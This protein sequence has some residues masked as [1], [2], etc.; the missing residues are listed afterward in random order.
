MQIG[1]KI[2]VVLPANYYFAVANLPARTVSSQFIQSLACTLQNGVTELNIVCTVSESTLF[3]GNIQLII[4]AGRLKTGAATSQDFLF[5]ESTTNLRSVN[6]KMLPIKEGRILGARMQVASSDLFSRRISQSN[7]DFFF[8]T[9]GDMSAGSTITLLL[10]SSF[11]SSRTNPSAF[12]IAINGGPMPAVSCQLLNTDLLRIVCRI[13][14][15]NPPIIAMS[16]LYRLMFPPGQLTFGSHAPETS[17]GLVIQ[18]SEDLPSD[19]TR[20][21]RILVPQVMSV[22]MKISQQDSFT[23]RVTGEAVEFSFALQSDLQL[24]STITIMLPPNYFVNK[25]RPVASLMCAVC[26]PTEI[27]IVDCFLDS[28]ILT[29]VC[30]TSN[31]ILRAGLVTLFF[32]AGEMATGSFGGV[33]KTLGIRV[34]ASDHITSVML[35]APAIFCMPGHGL[36]K[37]GECRPCL[38]GEFSSNP[39]TQPCELCPTTA[40]SANPSSTVCSSCGPFRS[41]GYVGA[42]SQSECLCNDGLY[43]SKDFKCESCSPGGVCSNSQMLSDKQFWSDSTTQSAQPIPC[44]F[45]PDACLAGSKCIDGHFGF[46]CSECRTGYFSLGGQCKPCNNENRVQSTMIIVA[47]TFS[48]IAMIVL[49]VKGSSASI[50]AFVQMLQIETLAMY[51]D[52]S[53]PVA[54][55][56]ALTSLSVFSLNPELLMLECSMNV[57]DGP[58]DRQT[59]MI[60]NFQA[61]ITICSVGTYGFIGLGFLF[62]IIHLHYNRLKEKLAKDDKHLSHANK[63][64]DEFITLTMHKLYA[65]GLF[66]GLYVYLPVTVSSFEHMTCENDAGFSF[67]KMKPQISCYSAQWRNIVLPNCIFGFV[68]FTAGIPIMFCFMFMYTRKDRYNPV[69]LKS[70]AVFWNKYQP[71]LY[72]WEMVY[73]SRKLV[74]AFIIIFLRDYYLFQTTV[75]CVCWIAFMIVHFNS[76]PYEYMPLNRIESA[77]YL[78]AFFSVSIF[79]CPTLINMFTNHSTCDLFVQFLL[80][81]FLRVSKDLE[82]RTTYVT[83]NLTITTA[84]IVYGMMGFVQ[85]LKQTSK[86]NSILEIARHFNSLAIHLKDENVRLSFAVAALSLIRCILQR[87]ASFVSRDVEM[88]VTL[89]V[90]QSEMPEITNRWLLNGATDEEKRSLTL[91]LSCVSKSLLEQGELL[92]KRASFREITFLENSVPNFLRYLISESTVEERQIVQH[93]FRQMVQ[94]RFDRYFLDGHQTDLL[95]DWLLASDDFES[96]QHFVQIVFKLKHWFKRDELFRQIKKVPAFKKVSMEGIK[97][98]VSNVTLK[99][100]KGGEVIVVEGDEGDEM[101][102]ITEGSVVVLDKGVEYTDL[103]TCKV[104]AELGPGSYFGEMVLLTAGLHDKAKRTR[105]VVA[106]EDSELYVL[107]FDQFEVVMDMYPDLRWSINRE[108][109]LRKVAADAIAHSNQQTTKRISV[110]ELQDHAKRSAATTIEDP[111]VLENTRTTNFHG[112]EIRGQVSSTERSNPRASSG[113]HFN[114]PPMWCS[115]QTSNPDDSAGLE[116]NNKFSS[117]SLGTGHAGLLMETLKRKRSDQVVI[118]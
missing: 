71:S 86:S 5:V 69:F 52:T 76:N 8:A 72:W 16:G 32:R 55:Q 22:Q 35:E 47:F 17:G 85:E 74:M 10:P 87:D 41:T 89:L 56:T 20:T 38:P 34:A 68:F 59:S 65:C 117:T 19:G 4:D 95:S 93:L 24:G 105:T 75:F 25:S 26:A 82:Y 48:V 33:F 67:I 115:S 1:N 30:T 36:T 88:F 42:V 18:T 78:G 100:V 113:K 94:W 60:Y 50:N 83:L 110:I 6:G 57:G 14:E 80:T 96:V 66:F 102:F 99:F 107:K 61:F 2:I 23:N 27:P 15:A 97:A 108:A 31:F 98:L 63:Q 84:M 53:K 37:S 39:N 7:I 13:S 114:R 11:L 62:L 103:K 46:L 51:I 21:P 91:V 104:V 45:L 92:S 12:L 43:M 64:L 9:L 54:V 73:T 101:Y 81:F 106:K 70:Y 40:Y 58:G 118:C 28:K 111:T 109:D 112:I 3:A 116:R 77:F 29:I 44:G 79:H 90:S 49:T